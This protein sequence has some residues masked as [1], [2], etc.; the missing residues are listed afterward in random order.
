M[1]AAVLMFPSPLICKTRAYV[2]VADTG[3]KA[4]SRRMKNK[5]RFTQTVTVC[6][7]VQQQGSDVYIPPLYCV[8]SCDKDKSH[9][10]QK[11]SAN[12]QADHEGLRLGQ[13]KPPVPPILSSGVVS[14]KIAAF[15]EDQDGNAEN[16]TEPLPFRAPI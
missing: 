4:I 15:I 2:V 13:Q 11:G 12:V 1:T 6:L 10:S 5:K 7:Q 8:T 16:S 14:R 9:C 3:S